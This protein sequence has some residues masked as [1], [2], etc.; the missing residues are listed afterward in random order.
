MHSRRVFKIGDS[1]A[2]QFRRVLEL[3]DRLIAEHAEQ[4]ANDVCRVAVVDGD[5]SLAGTLVPSADSA[6][7]I[8]HLKQLGISAERQAM[9]VVDPVVASP[10]RI[11]VVSFAISCLGF[12][13]PRF[14][15]APLPAS[16]IETR[17]ADVVVA[18]GH[19]SMFRELVNQF[20]FFALGAVLR[21]SAVG[22]PQRRQAARSLLFRDSTWFAGGGMAIGCLCAP[23][24]IFKWFVL[25]A[26]SAGFAF[27]HP[28]LA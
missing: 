4:A 18:A 8:L 7:T 19:R 5:P 27:R 6:A 11:G 22:Y 28:T 23:M 10:H 26:N 3:S 17:F 2:E 21:Q 16:Q 12:I 20:S 9:I 1:F 25:A 15:C 14:C 13:S 24:K